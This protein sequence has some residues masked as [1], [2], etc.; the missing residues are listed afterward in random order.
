MTLTFPALLPFTVHA[1]RV[2]GQAGGWGGAAG[3]IWQHCRMTLQINLTLIIKKPICINRVKVLTRHAVSR[4]LWLCIWIF[5][6]YTNVKCNLMSC[7]RIRSWRLMIRISASIADQTNGEVTVVVRSAKGG[8]DPQW[9][10]IH[11]EPVALEMFTSWG[12]AA[13]TDFTCV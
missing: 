13:T 9:H 8:Q 1:P 3:S 10:F 4:R 7:Q 2:K 11:C 12:E 6:F 5:I